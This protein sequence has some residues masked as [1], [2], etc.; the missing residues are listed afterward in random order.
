MNIL[1]ISGRVS[2]VRA[3][4][5]ASLPAHAETSC[6][7]AAAPNSIPRRARR[8]RRCAPAGRHADARAPALA[9]RRA[10]SAR[11]RASRVRRSDRGR[12]APAPPPPA[13]IRPAGGVLIRHKWRCTLFR[14]CWMFREP[15]PSASPCCAPLISSRFHEFNKHSV[16]S[17]KCLPPWKI[18]K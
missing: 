7:P 1:W 17:P 11:R 8:T 6:A 14:P 12:R 5:T 18:L 10:A 13:P 9:G 2:A 16:P 3:A 4:C 15:C